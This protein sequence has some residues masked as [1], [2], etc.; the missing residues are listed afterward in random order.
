M[1]KRNYRKVI[2]STDKRVNMISDL[3]Q[4][5]IAVKTFCW[6]DSFE[7]NIEK[8]RTQEHYY[9][10]CIYIIKSINHALIASVPVIIP[11]IIFVFLW[12]QNKAFDLSI[13][14]YI[15][16]LILVSRAT[17]CFHLTQG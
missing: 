13:A 14:I 16:S 15:S 8:S 1:I 11:F 5:I 9:L 6:E 10:R 3:V 12:F 4:G 7:T 17:V 2:M